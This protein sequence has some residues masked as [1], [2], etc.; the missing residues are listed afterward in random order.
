M[1]SKAK[2]L[3][4]FEC[5]EKGVTTRAEVTGKDFFITELATHYSGTIEFRCPM[6]NQ[7]HTYE[8]DE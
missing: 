5:P 2:L 6:C 4:E 7:I 3:V 8:I 1:L